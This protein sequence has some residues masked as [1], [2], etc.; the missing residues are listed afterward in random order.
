MSDLVSSDVLSDEDTGETPPASQLVRVATD[1]AVAVLTMQAAPYNL[2]NREMIEAI[3]D[4]LGWAQGRQRQRQPP[5]RRRPKDRVGSYRVG[6]SV[7]HLPRLRL[8]SRICR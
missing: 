8:R 6:W 2:L 7:V 4:A 3:I 1:G 5:P